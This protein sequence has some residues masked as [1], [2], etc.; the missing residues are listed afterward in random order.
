MADAQETLKAFLR[1]FGLGD[2]QDVISAVWSFAQENPNLVNN[3]DLLINSARNTATYKARFK[4]NEARVKK[5]LPELS[6]ATYI[7]YEDAFKSALRRAGM[8]AGFYD[9]EASL[10]TFI[11]NDVDPDE[12]NERIQ[13]GYQAVKQADPQVVAELRRLYPVGDGDLAAYFIDPE[14]ARPTFDKYEA[15]RQARAAAIAAEAQKQASMTLTQQE[16]ESLARQG[17]TGETARQ[18]FGAIEQSRGLFE[19]QMAGEEAISR[20]EQIGAAFGT[21]AAA[22]QRIATRRRRRQAEFE[23]GGGFA[24]SQQG[25]AG[26]RTVGQ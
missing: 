6:P 2:A 9:D 1:P 11:G 5:G 10:A 4:G 20:E 21:S 23:T 14:R 22:Q 12:L 17:V 7:K 16:A 15:Q 26:L 25:V 24:T 19:P 3:T 13:L 18:G 8:P